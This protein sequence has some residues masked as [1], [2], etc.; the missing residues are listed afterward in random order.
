MHCLE[1]HIG[2]WQTEESL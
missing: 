1:F 2:D